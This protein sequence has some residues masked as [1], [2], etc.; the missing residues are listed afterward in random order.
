LAL[1]D[2]WD[3]KREKLVNAHTRA[4]WRGLK[5]GVMPSESHGIGEAV[6]LGRAIQDLRRIIKK[7]NNSFTLRSERSE[8]R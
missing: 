8:R 5:K 6:G 3:K 4:V 1:V 7:A 2:E